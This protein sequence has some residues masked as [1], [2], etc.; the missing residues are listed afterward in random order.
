SVLFL[1]CSG[2]KAGQIGCVPQPPQAAECKPQ[3]TDEPLPDFLRQMGGTSK[4][5]L[6]QLDQYTQLTTTE[7]LHPDL[8]LVSIGGNDSGFG[9]LVKTCVGPGDCTETGQKW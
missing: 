7:P 6:S 1:A 9:N 4:V 8:V 3:Y 5:G 2:A